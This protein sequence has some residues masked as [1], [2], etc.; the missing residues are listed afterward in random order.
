MSGPSPRPVALLL[1]DLRGGGAE[2]SVL[3]TAGE[4]VAA[5]R[6]VDVVVGR[7]VG[8]LAAELPSGVDV[9][10][11]DRRHLRA[12]VGRLSRYL[13]ARR[14]THVVPTLEH[15]TVAATIAVAAARTDTLVVPRV[16]NTLS[17]TLATDRPLGR[18]VQLLAREVYRRSDRVVAVSEGVAEDLVRAHAVDAKRV[19]IVPNPVVGPELAARAAAPV[20]HPWFAP[21]QP[22]VVMGMG[23]LTAQKNFPLLLEAFARV[24]ASRLARLVILGEGEGRGELEARIRTLGVED[25]VQLPGFVSDPFPL[26]GRAKVFVLSSDYEGLPGSLIQ[27]IACGASPV[28]TDCESGPREILQGGRHGR[29]VPV[30][31]VDGLATAIEQALAGPR[32]E[33]GADVWGRWTTTAARDAWDRLLFDEDAWHRM[34]Q[35]AGAA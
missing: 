22:P 8:P 11:L 30:G 32:A 14:P 33:L 18:G 7:A 1:P 31:D 3:R 6:T 24:R 29:L 5:G 28:A 4:L 9:F 12:S 25:D 19:T 20:S 27:A 15:A 2:R 35:R 13:R 21:D 17:H 34:P 10:D 26:L 23:R 16:A